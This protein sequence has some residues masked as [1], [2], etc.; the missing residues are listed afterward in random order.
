MALKFILS[1]CVLMHL[2]GQVASSR[3]LLSQCSYIFHQFT[4]EAKGFAE[5][6][7][8]QDELEVAI[9]SI[10]KNVW[11]SRGNMIIKSIAKYFLDFHGN[12]TELDQADLKARVTSRLTQCFN[13]RKVN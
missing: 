6:D 11:D 9:E 4:E 2:I 1:I 3:T 12:I 8:T 5:V 13:I 10:A 7:A